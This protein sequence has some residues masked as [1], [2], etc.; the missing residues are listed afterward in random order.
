MYITTQIMPR[1]SNA[2]RNVREISVARR[3]E[4]QNTFPTTEHKC[5]LQI[6]VCECVCVG[7][8]ACAYVCVCVCVCV[9]VAYALRP[10]NH[11]TLWQVLQRMHLCISFDKS[12][13]FGRCIDSSGAWSDTSLAHHFIIRH[14]GWRRLIRSLIFMGHFPQK[15]PIFSGSFVKN[16][17]QLR[18]SYESSPPCIISVSL[19]HR[20]QEYRIILSQDK[21]IHLGQCIDS[22]GASLDMSLA[23]HYVIT[24]VLRISF[25]HSMDQGNWVN[26]VIYVVHDKKNH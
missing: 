7:V 21:S 23:Y 8:C 1:N 2:A 20:I 15:W 9:C 14:T 4:R 22:F 10:K 12:I 17:V 11:R 25:C 18:G 3:L 24:Y 16:D 5:A 6:C 13:H 19:Y 26:A